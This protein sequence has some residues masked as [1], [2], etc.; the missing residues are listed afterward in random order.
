MN[1]QEKAAWYTLA[2]IMMAVVA[3]CV[4][5]TLTTN[6][7]GS[8][9]AFALLGL[10][11]FL[12]SSTAAKKG[13][14]MG[15]E[16]DQFIALRA[17]QIT[18][19]IFWLYFVGYCMVAV[20]FWDYREFV[21][22]YL[23]IKFIWTGMCVMLG[24]KAIATLVLYSADA[25]EKHTMAERYRNMSGIRRTGLWII[26]LGMLA[27]T[28]FMILM[29]KIGK[30]EFSLL[31][32]YLVSGSLV[33]VYLL[34]RY[35]LGKGVSTEEEAAELLWVRRK[36]DITLLIGCAAVLVNLG[37]FWVRP[38]D[39]AVLP[40]ISTILLIVIMG[41]WLVLGFS[42]ILSGNGMIKDQAASAEERPNA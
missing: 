32:S 17:N 1:P 13:E 38:L 36:G 8:Q 26:V 30:G 34:T 23:F 42:T 35:Y 33:V 3:Y 31:F 9:A 29:L 12:G 21:P 18:F 2:V 11:G 6:P 16:R 20:R 10:L 25:T 37:L 39:R 7:A 24:T 27:M 41:A 4:L 15:D 5:L 28:P 14:F 40:V 19:P 22:S